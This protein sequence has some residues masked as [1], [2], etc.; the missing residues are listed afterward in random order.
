[1]M[2]A[3]VIDDAK[4]QEVLDT[5]LNC[6]KELMEYEL[7]ECVIVES[8]SKSKALELMGC[9]ASEK[10]F[11]Y[12]AYDINQDTR[13]EIDICKQ[14][15]R[16]SRIVSVKTIDGFEAKVKLS[17]EEWKSFVTILTG[18]AMVFSTKL[19]IKTDIQKL[20]MGKMFMA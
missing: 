16:G 14:L 4:K 1:M 7:R 19:R 18:C 15:L 17:A 8:L 11:H 9:F 2:N 6:F 5:I 3:T 20:T 12:K 13:Y 10:Y